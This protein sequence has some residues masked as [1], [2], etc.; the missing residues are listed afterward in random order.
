[1]KYNNHLNY[2]DRRH[3][4]FKVRLVFFCILIIGLLAAVYMY[5]T[6]VVQRESNTEDVTTSGQTN[7]YFA[8]S[9][10]IFRSPYFQFQAGNTWVE[11]PTESTPNK[12]VYRSLRSNLIEHELVVYVNQI[13]ADLSANRVLPVNIKSGGELLP[14]S[15][16][17]HCLKAAGAQSMQDKEVLMDRVKFLCDSDS[18]NY[19]VLAGMVDGTST[20]QLPRP[21]GTTASYVIRYTN[22]KATPESSQLI[23]IT[24]SFQS[25]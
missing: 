11:V 23:Q 3:F 2:Q 5:F 24:D 22:L 9:V 18:T 10:N 17:E 25:R 16:S 15:V 7:S 14:I 13:P 19:T 21:D 1:M 20:I 6:V 8:P 12:F 4:L